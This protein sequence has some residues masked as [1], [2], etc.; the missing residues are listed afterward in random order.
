MIEVERKLSVPQDMALPDLARE[1]WQV[2]GPVTLLLDATYWDTTDLRLARSRAT[3][4]RRT[5]GADAGW[6]LKLPAGADRE[7]VRRPLGRAGSVP[8]ALSDL[9]LSRTRGAALV[10]VLRIRTTRRTTTVSDAHG[11]PLVEVADDLVLAQRPDGTPQTSWREVEVE[12]VDPTATGAMADVVDVLVR[13]GAT[14]SPSASKLAQ[15]LA[16]DDRAPA[17][18]A[19]DRYAPGSAAAA[20]AAYLAEQ[21]TAIVEADPH[22]RRD[23]AEAVHALRVASRRLRS[24]LHTFRPVL[25]DGALADLEDELAWLASV[26]GEVRDRDV[27]RE[28]MV[29]QLDRLDPD[30]LLGPVRAHLL[31]DELGSRGAAAHTAALRALRGRRY[32]TLL[33]RLADLAAE[34]PL[35]DAA[36]GPARGVLPVLAQRAWQRLDRRARRAVASGLEHDLHQ[37]R[38]AAKQVRYTGEALTPSL[39]R[40]AERLAE[41]AKDVQTLLGE[42][43]DGVV[44]RELLLRLARTQE[45]S[46]TYGLLHAQEQERVRRTGRAFA[47]RWPRLRADGARR[48]E[49]VLDRA[50]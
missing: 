45:P 8:S 43:Q 41:V 13:A 7:E 22:V 17:V 24:A 50:R 4:R 2:L 19:H 33:D 34:P 5:G 20:V 25:Q 46:F 42:L 49:R 21:V 40:R 27:L 30:L 38:K 11:V 39:G 6:H 3:L 12:L 16:D 18:T 26:L 14:P 37:V 47:E 1:G 15:A 29:R 44:A 9:V 48:L 23:Q 36:D 32:L 31:D 35:T 28:R 10:P